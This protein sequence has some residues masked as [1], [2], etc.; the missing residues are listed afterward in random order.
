[1]PLAHAQ[2]SCM[3]LQVSELDMPAR[4]GCLHAPGRPLHAT[5]SGWLAGRPAAGA[6]AGACTKILD[7]PSSILTGFL[8]WSFLF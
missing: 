2:A 5:P 7:R 3:P 1:M 6:Q 8:I 4:S